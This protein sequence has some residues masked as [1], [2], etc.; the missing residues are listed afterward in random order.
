MNPNNKTLDKEAIC[1]ALFSRPTWLDRMLEEGLVPLLV[2]NDLEEIS[3][4]G[5][6][7]TRQATVD[8]ADI[9]YLLLCFAKA[10]SKNPHQKH[11]AGLPH[12]DLFFECLKPSQPWGRGRDHVLLT[13]LNIVLNV[14]DYLITI[15]PP[16]LGLYAYVP[17]LVSRFQDHEK[18]GRLSRGAVR[19]LFLRGDGPSH[20]TE[21]AMTRETET[22]YF[23]WLEDWEE[24]PE[25]TRAWWFYP[26]E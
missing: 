15:E 13:D 16:R 12:R 14:S 26:L 7:N 1:N 19:S 2:G 17:L 18:D 5:F 21:C 4:D 24:D 8:K 25:E 20:M 3:E 6:T 23:I 9:A 10:D 11:S 22:I